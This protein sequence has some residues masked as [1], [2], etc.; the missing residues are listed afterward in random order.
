[1]ATPLDQIESAA[2]QLTPAERVRLAERLL[3]SLEEDDEILAAW[4]DEAERRAAAFERGEIKAASLD[5]VLARARAGLSPA[6]GA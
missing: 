6:K 4:A 2:L 1:M 5:E 3:L